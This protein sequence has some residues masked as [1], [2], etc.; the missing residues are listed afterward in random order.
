MTRFSRLLPRSAR[1]FAGAAALLLA[2]Q[3]H[4][5][6]PT[7]TA[8]PSTGA[9]SRPAATKAPNKTK[10]KAVTIAPK[11]KGSLSKPRA[12]VA[13]NVSD[14]LAHTA[15]AALSKAE[16]AAATE[17]QIKELNWAY[18][19]PNAL[20]KHDRAALTL[21]RSDYVTGLS[22]RAV[23]R[24]KCG[25]Q[26]AGNATCR[27]G[28]LGVGIQASQPG[29]F[30]VN[31]TM[32]GSGMTPGKWIIDSGNAKTEIVSTVGQADQVVFVVQAASAGV[33]WAHLRGTQEA[34]AFYSC[35]VNTAS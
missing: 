7:A 22:N 4:A 23:F 5:G 33:F 32:R 20:T 18:L 2:V 24:K 11:A 10:H 30:V 15:P 16:L 27:E 35:A 13:K 14:L 28:Y 9:S 17:L 3:A 25:L 21:V 1:F 26:Q 6:R 19:T 12:R 8:T 34:W 29:L 31:C